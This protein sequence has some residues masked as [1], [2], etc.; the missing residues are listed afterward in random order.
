VKR[1]H[2]DSRTKNARPLSSP[3]CC[4][5]YFLPKISSQRSHKKGWWHFSLHEILPYGLRRRFTIKLSS[6][7]ANTHKN[8]NMIVN[9]L[10]ADAFQ[11]I[12]GCRNLSLLVTVDTSA[13]SA[14]GTT[15]I[16]KLQAKHLDFH[17]KSNKAGPIQPKH[18]HRLKATAMDEP[19]WVD[20]KSCDRPC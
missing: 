6:R 19:R 2:H 5:W 17:S 15:S 12:V 16:L 1:V 11:S 9:M 20:E 4:K 7:R 3:L 18:A 10:H 13:N 14:V 8:Y